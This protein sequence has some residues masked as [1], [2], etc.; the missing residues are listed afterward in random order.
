MS[1]RS[2]ADLG[3]DAL[4]EAAMSAA[5]PLPPTAFDTENPRGRKRRRESTDDGDDTQDEDEDDEL[6]TTITPGQPPEAPVPNANKNVIAFAK[7]FATHKRLRPSQ[8]SEV[9]VFAADPIA[10]RQIKMYTV[11]LGIDSRLESMRTSAPDFKISSALDKNMK[12]LAIGI[13]LSPKLAAYKGTLPT[14]HLLSI[15]KKKRFDLPVGIELIASDW[16]VVKSRVEYHLTQTRASF[17]KYLAKGVEDKDPKKHTNI[18]VLGQ[19]FVHDTGTTLTTPLCA[20][21]AL[22]RQYLLLH[23]GEVFWDKLDERLAWIRTTSNGDYN[24]QTKMFKVFLSDDRDKHGNRAEY[25]LPEDAVVDEWQ[26]EVDV[27]VDP[28]ATAA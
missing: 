25:A 3:L 5:S 20:R 28:D 27:V 13:L 19:R 26:A 10:T 24:K 16:A 23:P 1:A 18:F 2:E 9:E 12:K 15:L 8:I 11:L 21:I 14:K 4:L 17:K 22:M 7:Q 6:P